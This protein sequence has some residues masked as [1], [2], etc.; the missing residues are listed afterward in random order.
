MH[1]GVPRRRPQLV[2]EV[3]PRE[4]WQVAIKQDEVD[5][6]GPYLTERGHAIGCQ[7]CCIPRVLQQRRE[8]VRSNRIGLDY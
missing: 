6:A 4:P 8:G 1:R 5:A 2:A 7:R 3:K